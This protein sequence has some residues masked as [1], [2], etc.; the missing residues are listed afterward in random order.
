M[1]WEGQDGIVGDVQDDQSSEVPRRESFIR[2]S[3]RPTMEEAA[4][5]AAILILQV[6]GSAHFS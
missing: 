4:H 5:L 6:F 3:I 2:H 1:T